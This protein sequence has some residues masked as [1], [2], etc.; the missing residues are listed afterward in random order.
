ML[1]YSQILGK[2]HGLFLNALLSEIMSEASG[3]RVKLYLEIHLNDVIVHVG[4][5]NMEFQRR[6][7][8]LWAVPI[9]DL[10]G[11]PVGLSLEEKW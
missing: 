6:F 10:K 4:L 9:A 8:V 5:S 7:F 1:F 2:V 11:N 3:G